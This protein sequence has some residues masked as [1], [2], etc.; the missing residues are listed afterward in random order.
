VPWRFLDAGQLSVRSH[1]LAGVQKPAQKAT[2]QAWPDLKEAARWA[3]LLHHIFE[4]GKSILECR[5]EQLLIAD[6]L[7]GDIEPRAIS[8]SLSHAEAAGLKLLQVLT[9]PRQAGSNLATVLVPRG[10]R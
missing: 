8:R 1:F 2:S 10:W 6:K 4:R 5:D 3:S 7:F 9:L